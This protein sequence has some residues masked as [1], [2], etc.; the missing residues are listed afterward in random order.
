MRMTSSSSMNSEVLNSKELLKNLPRSLIS[1]Y[2]R[3]KRW[4]THER[5][6]RGSR[7]L[8]LRQLPRSL[9]IRKFWKI[10]LDVWEIPECTGSTQRL[11]VV[12]PWLSCSCPWPYTPFAALSLVSHACLYLYD[13]Y[14]VLM[15]RSC[16]VGMVDGR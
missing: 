7:Q 16:V 8:L 4:A 1:H 2:T 6:A 12:R 10:S 11:R 9:P 15:I 5:R 13:D 3:M 14:V